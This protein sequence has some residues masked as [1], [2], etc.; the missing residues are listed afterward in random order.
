MLLDVSLPVGPSMSPTQE[1]KEGIILMNRELFRAMAHA[2]HIGAI[3]LE[4]NL[5]KH[6]QDN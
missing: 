5:Q 2:S 1:E 3:F 4:E 6:T